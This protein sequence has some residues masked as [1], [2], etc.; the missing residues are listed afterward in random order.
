[1]PYIGYDMNSVTYEA[2]GISNYDALQVQVRKRL[3]NGLQFTAVL[4]LVARPRRAERAG[5]VRHGEQSADS[6]SQLCVGG[7]RSDARFPDQLQLHDSRASP[8]TARLWVTLVNGWIIGG[9]TVAQ[10]GQPYSVYDYS[11]SV[12]EPLL[13]HRTMRSSNPIVPLAPGV[14][15]KQAELQGTTGVNAGKPVLN[16]SDFLPQFVAARHRTACLPATPPG[17]MTTSPL[18]GTTGRNMFRG[19][20]QVALRYEPGQGVP[21]H[22]GALPPALRG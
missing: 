7:L 8:R 17:A 14:T 1:M 16:A 13:R 10:S 12:G 3:S 4:H 5:P 9:Q 22:Q 11:G 6:Q 18:F 21:H 2:E 20:F 19:P 15:A